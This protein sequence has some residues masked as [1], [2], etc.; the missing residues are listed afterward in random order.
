MGNTRG[1]KKVNENILSDGRALIFTEK[2][3]NKYRWEDIP[4]GSK[5]IDITTGIEMVKLKGESDW[6]PSGIKNDGTISIAKDSR[7]LEEIFTIVD[8]NENEKMF[9]YKTMSGE[10]RHMPKTING[11]VFEL[12][13]GSY[14]I[15]R[16]HL[17][18]RIDNILKRDS[19]AGEVEE[20]TEQRFILKDTLLSG[21]KI[22][23]RYMN[24]L[25][26]GN[27]YPRMFLQSSTPEKGENGDFWLDQ[28]YDE[29]NDA[30]KEAEKVNN[31][32]WSE[33]SGKPT[34]ISG[35]GIRDNFSRVGH[36]HKWADIE[37]APD[38]LLANGGNSKTVDGCY[39]GTA[40]DNVLKIGSDGKIPST[41][42]T[43]NFL[44]ES[45]VLFIQSMPPP[46]PKPSA[47][48]FDTSTGK[49]CIK[50]YLNGQWITFGTAWKA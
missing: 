5:F 1:V 21:Q 3:K 44:N 32:D 24:V 45:K 25:R 28:N 15:N 11:Y 26:I 27:P 34:T 31:V 36:L 18:V 7:V 22:Y 49:E 40:P 50:V 4:D 23:V 17:E 30:N 8:P 29:S 48:W 35:Y 37:D 39:V 19:Q 42:L 33:I 2:D 13:R 46:N 6:V 38:A 12:E 41:L 9:S 10:I 43:K 47:L 14:L 20:L 16:N